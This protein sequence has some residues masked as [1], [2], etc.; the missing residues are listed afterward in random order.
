MKRHSSRKF[1]LFCQILRAQLQRPV[2]AHTQ[3]PKNLTGPGAAPS[4]QLPRRDLKF[5]NG[6]RLFDSLVN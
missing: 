2:A 4:M 1:D 3:L 6:E 5:D